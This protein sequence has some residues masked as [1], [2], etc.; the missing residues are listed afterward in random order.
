MMPTVR[1]NTAIGL[2]GALSTALA[3]C[4]GHHL[5][6][7]A[8]P[9]KAG[10]ARPPLVAPMQ[11]HYTIERDGERI[12]DE[13][14][15]VTSSAGVWRVEGEVKLE[16]PTASVHGYVLE[17]DEATAEPQRFHVWFELYGARRE[18]TGRRTEDGFIHVETTGIGGTRT[19]EVPYAAGTAIAYDSPLFATMALSL[20]VGSMQPET[21][22][23]VRTIL[24][25]LPDLAP[26][27]LLT[28]YRL[29]AREGAI[30]KVVV[31]RPRTKLP[32]ALWVRDD[33]LPVRVRT[34]VARGA[35][36]IERRLE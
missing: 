23:A 33:G 30:A 19:K 29:E 9:P 12:G 16:S 24:L 6:P 7:A 15:T 32:V 14:F 31:E 34:F 20:L 8:S 28:T 36:P 21:P 3:G 27:V 5:T 18:A 17:I 10:A 26:T 25:P 1:K 35:P 22:V 2:C 13:R 4:Y 11:G